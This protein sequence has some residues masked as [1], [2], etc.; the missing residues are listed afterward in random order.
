MTEVEEKMK[1]QK[2]DVDMKKTDN[3]FIQLMENVERQGAIFW[4]ENGTLHYNAPKGVMTQDILAEMSINKERFL[5]L[6]QICMSR[7]P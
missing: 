5:E 7:F 2:E 1:N 6:L 4:E 3:T